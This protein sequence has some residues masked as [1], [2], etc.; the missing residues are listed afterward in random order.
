MDVTTRAGRAA[1]ALAGVIFVV[2]QPDS[3]P[4]PEPCGRASELAARDGHTISVRC[5]APPS[6]PELR[7]PA[8]RL[9]G[10]P[11]D[12]NLADAATLETLPGIGVVRAAAIVRERERGR[13]ESVEDLL[14]VRGIGPATLARIAPLLAVKSAPEAG[15]QE[16]R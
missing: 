9:F 6:E 11:F 10:L 3:R 7:G 8:R 15:R 13:F 16:T 4:V 5:D 2:A 12:P 1:F 14:R